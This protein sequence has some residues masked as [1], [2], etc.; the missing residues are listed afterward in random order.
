MPLLASEPVCLHEGVSGPLH[1]HHL[2][3]PNHL[4]RNLGNCTFNTSLGSSLWILEFGKHSPRVTGISGSYSKGRKGLSYHLQTSLKLLTA[5]QVPS[6][7]SLLSFILTTLYEVEATV[8]LQMRHLR[9]SK[10]K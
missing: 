5:Y 9:L 6:M 2:V 3:Y 4:R 8:I 1:Q 7:Y 10:Y